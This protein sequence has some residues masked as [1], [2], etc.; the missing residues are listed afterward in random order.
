[1]HHRPNLGSAAYQV[2]AALKKVHLPRGLQR[3]GTATGHIYYG[4]DTMH[5]CVASNTRFATWVW[6]RYGVKDIRQ[7]TPEHG[8][9]YLADL[10]SREQSD[11]YIDQERRAME[12]LAL[13]LHGEPWEL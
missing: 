12:Q 2:T 6:Y 11:K 10:A 5:D 4:S 9:A 8:L 1:M 7:I 13:A 3:D